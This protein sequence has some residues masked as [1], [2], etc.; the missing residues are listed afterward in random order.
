[1]KEGKL[2]SPTS[3][4]VLAQVFGSL[5]AVG[6]IAL[7]YRPAFASPLATAI[8][9]G[10]CAAL[11]S[12]K[13]EAPPWWAP[14]HLGFMPLIVITLRLDLP[15]SLYLSVF[16]L[17]FLTFWRTG[18]S[19]V[20]LYLTNEQTARTIAAILPTGSC[21]VVD[22]GCGNG[23]LLKR[24]GCHRPDLSF[25]GIE[26]APLPCLWAWIMNANQPNTCVR[27]GNFWRQDF[28][29]FDVVYAFLSPVPMTNLWEKVRN[30]MG[31]GGLL[32]SNSFPVPDV[33]P[34][35]VMKVADKRGTRLY[36]YRLP[37]KKGR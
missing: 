20:P 1:M 12:K 26:H 36:C 8:V 11:V 28:S 29:R 32:I 14:L 24:L 7:I 4:A 18:K 37:D 21:R 15:P 31:P 27:L 23:R 10:I 30:E 22:I 3:M 16:L 5:I 25:V 19:K 33:V 13:L 6:L 17:L 9:Q 2:G 35:Q 34:D